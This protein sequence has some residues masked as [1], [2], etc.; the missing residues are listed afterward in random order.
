MYLSSI[1]LFCSIADPSS[2]IYKMY[3]DIYTE[4][5]QTIY[6]TSRMSIYMP[7]PKDPIN[8]LTDMF[9]LFY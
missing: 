9:L 2:I 6:K 3:I 1:V 7:V 4:I 8:P 5:R